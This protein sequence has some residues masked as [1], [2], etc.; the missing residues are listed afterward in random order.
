MSMPLLFLILPA[1]QNQRLFAIRNMRKHALLYA[2]ST[3]HKKKE[4]LMQQLPSKALFQRII[5]FLFHQVFS[6][7]FLCFITCFSRRFRSFLPARFQS[8]SSG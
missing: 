4:G 7:L 8:D 2:R 5:P 1:K 3:N 6:E